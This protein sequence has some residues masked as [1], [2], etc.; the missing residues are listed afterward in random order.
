MCWIL[1]IGLFFYNICVADYA[2]DPF[3][4]IAS[5]LFAIAG[6][7]GIRQASK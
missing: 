1:C 6:A 2:N 3:I 4:F 7:I 5:A